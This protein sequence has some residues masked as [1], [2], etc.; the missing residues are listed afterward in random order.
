VHRRQPPA[1]ITLNAGREG[2]VE[3]L[4]KTSG[5]DEEEHV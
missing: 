5:V 3:R 1:V 4:A 2:I